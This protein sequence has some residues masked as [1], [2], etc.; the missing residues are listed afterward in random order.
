MAYSTGAPSNTQ[1]LIDTFINWLTTQGGFTLGNTWTFTSDTTNADASTGTT[2]YTA[3]ALLR[4][5]QYVLVAWKTTS[6]DH[7]WLNTS[8]NNPTSGRI[9]VQTGSAE[10]SQAVELGT[11]PIK[12]HLFSDGDGCHCVVEWMGGVFAHINVGFVQKYGSWAGGLY[13]TGTYW[14]R[15]VAAGSNFHSWDAL[16]Y[17]SRPFDSA[18]GPSAQPGHIRCSYLSQ[19]VAVFGIESQLGNTAIGLPMYLKDGLY[20]SPNAY[21][22][23][24]VLSPIEIMV[25]L[26]DSGT[27]TYWRPLGR[28]NNAA[29]INIGNLN[30][31]DTI[32]TDWMVFPLSAKNS[33]GSV[34][35]G[36]I[37]SLVYGMAYKK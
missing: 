12:Y 8:T 7:I 32:L 22:G 31:G 34:A 37:N 21:N 10:K 28:V 13:V 1:N 4:D 14:S 17:H 16:N 11:S 27:P 18:V 20:R 9:N 33:G 23:R 36:Y 2:S 25:G 19:T 26:E 24:A 35:S 6:P 15:W 30:A 5:G 29:Y 3:R